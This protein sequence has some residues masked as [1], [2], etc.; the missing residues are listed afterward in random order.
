M[1]LRDFI[2]LLIFQKRISLR[3]FS[4]RSC[5]R[6]QSIIRFL[7]GGNL[8]L[9]NLEKVL[10]AL[11]YHLQIRFNDTQEKKE[12]ESR[13]NQRL[14]LNKVALVRFCKKHGVRFLAIY[15]SVLRED[16]YAKSDIDI[17]LDFHKRLTYFDL[18]GLEEELQHLFRT[19]HP[20]HIIT[21]GGLS[22]IIAEEV[23]NHSEVIYAKAA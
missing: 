20:V 12:I 2:R 6:R 17:L 8:H 7:E 10:L 5:V 9:K 16:F 14:H 18:L 15:G 11:G 13:L 3:E 19:K 23:M 1:R 21:I 4:R 22:P